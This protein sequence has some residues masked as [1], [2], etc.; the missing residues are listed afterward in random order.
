MKL[1]VDGFG[2]AGLVRFGA[3]PQL[4]QRG[5]DRRAAAIVDSDEQH[6]APAAAEWGLIAA[7][8]DTAGA[9]PAGYEPVATGKVVELSQFG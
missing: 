4:E 5:E 8:A 9:I 7:Y 1:I 2:W 6:L 3:A